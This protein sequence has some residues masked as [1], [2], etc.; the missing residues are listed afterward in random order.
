MMTVGFFILLFVNLIPGIIGLIIYFQAESDERNIKI[1]GRNAMFRSAI[2]FV[3]CLC[4][5]FFVPENKRYLMLFL[6]AV[7]MIFNVTLIRLKK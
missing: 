1:I 3:I 5:Y 4:T 7:Y 6:L 2:I